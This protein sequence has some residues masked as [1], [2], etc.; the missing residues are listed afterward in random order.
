MKLIIFGVLC[1]LAVA[2]GS[3]QDVL[4]TVENWEQLF[5]RNYEKCVK[6]SSVDENEAKNIFKSL[7]FPEDHSFKCFVKCQ[8]QSLDFVNSKGEPNI[9]N[10]ISQAKN[11]DEK[12][13]K[14][15]AEVASVE[16]D[17]CDKVFVMQDVLDT[18]E[19]W[20][21]LFGRN[22]EKCVKESGVDENEAINTFK[23]LKFP[24]DRSFRCFVK[25]E[26]QSLDFVNS[27][28][29]PIVENLISQ[30]KN[31]NEKSIEEAM[32][33]ASAETDICDKVFIFLRHG[34]RSILKRIAAE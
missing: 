26:M 23:T 31:V 8:M 13:V 21:Q 24:E 5:S 4:D 16:T 25:C 19:N 20:G 28:G 30:A 12:I 18:V 33:V 27:R 32:E 34:A 14:M 10:L 3:K 17:L 7:K 9:Q 2:S 6:E 22:F 11:V 29:E 1:V 15:S